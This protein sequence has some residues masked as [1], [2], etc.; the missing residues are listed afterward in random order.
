M[1]LYQRF[2]STAFPSICLQLLPLLPNVT[3]VKVYHRRL[4][5]VVPKVALQKDPHRTNPA[6]ATV[7]NDIL[8]RRLRGVGT[9]R[10]IQLCSYTRMSSFPAPFV[11]KPT[12][13]PSIVASIRNS[14]GSER[15]LSNVS[16][17]T[18]AQL[19]NA[20]AKFF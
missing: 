10:S 3:V 5:T 11:S 1:E 7:L 16:V 4:H 15:S 9:L 8:F 19:F 13:T 17:E 6:L 2:G 18:N 14:N 12:P 20:A